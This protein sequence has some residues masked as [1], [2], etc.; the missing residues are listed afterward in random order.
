VRRP[1]RPAQAL[2]KYPASR[3]RIRRERCA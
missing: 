1:I 3:E 2:A